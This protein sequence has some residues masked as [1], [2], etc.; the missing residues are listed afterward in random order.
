MIAAV[1]GLL[2]SMAGCYC[3]LLSFPLGQFKFLQVIS[4]YLP[5]TLVSR[6][7]VIVAAAA[8]VVVVVVVVYVTIFFQ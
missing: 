6:L 5:L 4:V 3:H 7:I 1:F 2:G 8:A